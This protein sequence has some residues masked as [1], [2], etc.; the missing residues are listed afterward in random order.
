MHVTITE[1]AR[2]EFAARGIRATAIHNGFARLRGRSGRAATRR[3]LGVAPDERL[4]L[5][6]VRAIPRKNIPLALSL[7]EQTGAA[8]WLTGP[9]EDGFGRALDGLLRSTSARVLRWA[10]PR[11]ELADA[12]AASDA[13]MFPSTWE[14]FGNPPIEAALARRPAVVGTYPAADELRAVGFRWIDPTDTVALERALTEPDG[15]SLEHNHALACSRF[16]VRAVR[17]SLE[18]LLVSELVR[19]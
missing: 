3:R 5:H 15:A 14:G 7:A 10:V 8:Y 2:R 9:A 11:H 19:A 6:P 12:Y 16:S 13:V 1:H 18:R 17:D 4:L